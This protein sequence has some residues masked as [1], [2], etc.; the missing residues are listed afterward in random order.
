MKSISSTLG[1]A[2]AFMFL[3]ASPPAEATT[4]T[5]VVVTIGETKYQAVNTGWTF[6]VTLLA[7]QDLVLTQD[8]H[9]APNTTTSYNFDTSDEPDQVNP[10]KPQIAITADGLTT[11]FT[12]INQ[13]L[14]VG[15]RGS[16][17]F[18]LNEAQNYGAALVGPGYQVFLGYA[19]N[20][21]PGACGG[22]ATSLGLLGSS[23]CF[24]S[25]FSTATVFQGTGALVP[26]LPGDPT[27]SPIVEPDDGVHCSSALHNCYDAGVIRI[28]GT[29]SEVPEPAT[30]GLLLTGLAGLTARRYRQARRA[31]RDQA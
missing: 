5:S 29:T 7:G 9:G 18:D 22:Y 15:G 3:W 25:P 14:D 11:V 23:T 30:M 4:I 1:L 17:G 16:V 13:V 2:C 10:P 12:D 27:G 31:R 21:H 28:V 24:P 20:V 26:P 6:P 19:D 8:F